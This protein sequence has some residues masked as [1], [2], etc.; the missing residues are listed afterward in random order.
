MPRPRKCRRICTAPGYTD[1][2]P[3]DGPERETVTMELDEYE[4][5]RLIDLEGMTQEQC[6]GQMAVARTTVQSIYTSARRKLAEC[7]VHG[8]RLR[9]GGGDVRFCEHGGQDCGRGCCQGWRE[10]MQKAERGKEYE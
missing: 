10:E 7:I 8:R 5:I 9:I 6:A 3:G 1:F 4:T 2:F